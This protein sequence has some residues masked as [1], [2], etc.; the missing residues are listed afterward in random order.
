MSA[1]E[2]TNGALA[3][4]GSKLI[5]VKMNGNNKPIKLPV[6]TVRIIVKVTISTIS[7]ALKLAITATPTAMVTPRSKETNSSFVINLY[8][9]VSLTSPIA[10]ERIIKVADCA[11]AFPPLSIR[12]G[13]KNTRETA[14]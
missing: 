9:S 4:A 5:F 13:K 6:I 11:P 3:V 8:Q 2:V 14:D 10:N 12:S 7:G 1:I